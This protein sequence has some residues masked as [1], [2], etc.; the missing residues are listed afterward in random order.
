MGKI[1]ELRQDIVEQ[2]AAGEVVENPASVIKEL[3]ENSV[4]AG[5]NKIFIEIEDGGKT[6]IRVTDD[7]FGMTKEDA[8]LSIKRHATSKLDGLS[9][10]FNIKTLGFRG[11]ALAAIS[12]VSNFELLTKTDYAMEGT[13]VRL[14]EGEPAVETVACPKGTTIVVKDLFFNTPARKKH[15]RT[16]AS[17]ANKITEITTKYALVNPLVYF[18]LTIDGKTILNSPNTASLY[19]NIVDIYG[20]DVAKELVEVDYSDSKYAIKGYVS[21]PSFSR[22]DKDFMNIFINGRYVRNKTITD[23]VFD[24]YHTL[25]HGQRYPFA[26]LQIAIEPGK[27]DVNIHPNKMKIKIEEEGK[28]YEVIFDVVRNALKSNDILSGPPKDSFSQEKISGEDER[29]EAS[30]SQESLENADDS[31]DADNIHQNNSSAVASGSSSPKR[32]PVSPD[33]QITL[34]E[35]NKK[36]NSETGE[37]DADSSAGTVSVVESDYNSELLAGSNSESDIRKDMEE[38]THVTEGSKS[39]IDTSLSGQKNLRVIGQISRTYILI[40]TSNGLAIMDQHA[41]HERI[42]FDKILTESRMSIGKQE[43]ISPVEISVGIRETT[44]IESNKSLLRQFGF[45]IENFGGG[46]YLLRSVPVV[47]KKTLGNDFFTNLL[48]DIISHARVN[49]LDKMK[50][51]VVSTMACKAAIKAGDELTLDVMKDIV[52]KFFSLD[53]SY[54]CPHGRPIVLEISID[55]LEKR[56]KRKGF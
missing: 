35:S 16:N 25:L 28:L 31:V 32:Y 22:S 5:A 41:A 46:T 7:G 34:R 8:A 45:E 30:Q 39:T 52:A 53:M 20:N 24:S 14:S 51:E 26:L 2:I 36:E 27:L 55:E 44:A 13:R 42:L 40:E 49:S 15:L 10:L 9:D 33:E 47:F 6:L 12:S 3:I 38:N 11:E 50:H 21:K 37:K 23:A 18:R 56:F 29:K 43:L 4:D 54:T 48:T 19:N 1:K 17:E